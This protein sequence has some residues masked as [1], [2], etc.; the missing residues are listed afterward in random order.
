MP[1]CAV[2]SFMP[3]AAK[4]VCGMRGVVVVVVV[5]VWAAGVGRGW[6]KLVHGTGMGEY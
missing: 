5:V 1:N 4:S 3:H 2:A 6:C